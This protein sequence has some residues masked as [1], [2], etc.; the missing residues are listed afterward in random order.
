MMSRA[1]PARAGPAARPPARPRQPGPGGRVRSAGAPSRAWRRGSSCATSTSR[2]AGTCRSPR[3]TTPR[4]TPP[5]TP[6]GDAAETPWTTLLDEPFGNWHVDT[7]TQTLQLRVTKKREAVVHTSDRG[8]AGRGRPRPRPGQGAAAARGRPGARG[9]RASPTR[10]G[11]IKPSRQAKYRQ[12][13]EFL[14]L[15]DASITDALDKGHLRRPTPEEPLR[16]VDLGCGNAYLTFAAHRFL[17]DV[18][19]L[20]VRADRRRRQGAVRAST[21]AASP[22]RSASTRDFVVGTIAGVDARRAARRGARPARLRH[23]D[24]RGAGPR[25][26]VGGRAG[27]GRARAATT[28]SR[29]AA[30]APTPAPYALLTR[31]GILRERFA[32]TLTD[33]LRASLLR[34]QGYRVDVVEFVESKHTPAQHHAARGPHRR[35]GHGR[36]RAQ[37]YDELVDHLGSAAAARRAA[38]AAGWRERRRGGRASRSPFAFVIG[39]PPAPAAT[40]RWCSASR[41]PRSW[42]PAGWSS[43]R[44]GLVTTNDSGDT[45]RV[46][47]VDAATGETVGVTNWADEPDD[48]EALAPAG[49]GH[50][51]VGDIGDNTA[52]RDS[53]EVTRCPWATAT[54]PSTGD[55]RPGLSRRRRATPS[56][57]SCTPSPAGCYVATKDVLGGE[58]YAAPAR[59]RRRAQ[60]AGRWSARSLP[61]VTD[62]AFFP[63]GEHLVLRTYTNAVVYTFPAWSRSA[64]FDLPEPG[65]G[66]GHRRPRR[67]FV[68]LS[69]EGPQA[70]VLQV[71][72]PP[73]TWRGAAADALAAL[74]VDLRR[75]DRRP[76]RGRATAR[77]GGPRRAASRGC[78]CWVRFFVGAVVVVL[79]AGVRP[80]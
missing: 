10:Q 21:T 23:R 80:R 33:A 4:R 68:Y 52:C 66:R 17:T 57:C 58:L 50:V 42:S 69:C 9:A 12:V 20:P 75:A 19:G 28:T 77:R 63:D 11:R 72:L 60:P 46:F 62:G 56:R 44:P 7:T 1:P 73:A 54:G 14:R 18:R 55:L 27:A 61:V 65:A 35:A 32:D 30:P 8:R 41:T 15:L 25:G 79:T 26:R 36:R 74:A 59:A 47:T 43:R 51:W 2:P 53:I 45:G 67:R 13:E 64:T 48:V 29:P 3:T 71:A 16:I 40:A 6:A 49:A 24:R 78:G 5:T 34:L 39:R 76:T 22:R 38:G 70:P 37:E 31:H